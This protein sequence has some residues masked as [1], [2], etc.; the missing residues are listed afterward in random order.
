[1]IRDV[2]LH[3]HGELPMLADLDDLPGP[4]D[5]TIRCTNIRTVDGKRPS[6]VENQR[7]TFVFSLAHI[8]HIEAP[9]LER[10]TA[11]DEEEEALEHLEALP[12]DVGEEPDEDLLERIRRA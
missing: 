11:A 12:P 2:I 9:S 6:F 8:R 3:I 1:M 10:A 7:S 5:T 4:A